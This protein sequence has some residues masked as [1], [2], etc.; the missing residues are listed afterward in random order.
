MSLS[1]SPMWTHRPGSPSRAVDCWTFCSHRTLSFFSIGT[2]VGLIFFLSASVPLN[3]FRVQNFIAVSPP[4]E[5]L[6]PKLGQ[7]PW[8][9]GVGSGED[10][11]VQGWDDRAARN[12][13][14]CAE[15]VPER[16]VELGASFED[17][18]EHITTLAPDVRAGATGTFTPGD[19][20][21]DVVPLPSAIRAS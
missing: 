7:N 2:R 13:E 17:G 4:A 8:P 10:E 11:F 9:S 1:R 16:D 21:A 5:P 3:F 18:K 12:R 6:I 15:V 14:S 20:A 19:M